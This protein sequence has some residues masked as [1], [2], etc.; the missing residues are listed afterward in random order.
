MKPWAA[1]WL[2]SEVLGSIRRPAANIAEER[3]GR[4]GDI[5]SATPSVGLDAISQ[6]AVR[7][8]PMPE[9]GGYAISVGAE[10]ARMN[11]R[12]HARFA[13]RGREISNRRI[14]KKGLR[15]EEA[16]HASGARVRTACKRLARYPATGGKDFSTSYS[17]PHRECRTYSHIG[18]APGMACCCIGFDLVRHIGSI[19]RIPWH[20]TRRLSPNCESNSN[21]I[22][23]D[24]ARSRLQAS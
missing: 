22:Q 3:G 2:L 18:Q 12:K 7:S 6:L 9:A 15:P 8:G 24:A 13:P 20:G 23:A 1:R 11:I 21:P 4:S 14:V 16:A 17:G 19:R 5:R 10:E